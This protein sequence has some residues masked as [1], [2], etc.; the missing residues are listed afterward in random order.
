MQ[1]VSGPII[2]AVPGTQSK[3]RVLA[4]VLGCVVLLPLLAGCA[5]QELL[6]PKTSLYDRLLTGNTKAPA[7][8]GGQRNSSVSLASRDRGAAKFVGSVQAGTD[9]LVGRQGAGAANGL[10][11]EEKIT[12][13]LVD[14]PIANAAKTILS[15]ILK[16]SYSIDGQVSGTVTLQTS[17][18]M[19][20]SQVVQTFEQVLRANGAAI[21]RQGDFYRIVPAGQTA[22][23]VTRVETADSGQPAGLGVRTQVISLKYV[24]ADELRGVLEPLVPDGAIRKVD[25]AR[26]AIVLS[27]TSA[28]LATMRENIALFDVDWLQGMSFALFPVRSSS[29]AAIAEELDTIFGT[30]KGPLKGVV[31]FVPNKRLNA[32]LVISSRA[33]YLRESSQWIRK[34]DRLAGDNETELHVYNVQNRTASELAKVLQSVYRSKDGQ[35]V[36]IETTGVAP[37]LEAIEVTSQG[38]APPQQDLPPAVSE[39]A[40]GEVDQRAGLRVVA[41]D[42]NNVSDVSAYGTDL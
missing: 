37:R 27:G 28:E 3:C 34:L 42:A 38:D 11:D 25:S 9:Q 36:S 12:L 35:R 1:R 19:A 20:V 32:V 15:D 14:V 23:Q 6:E 4:F 18:P 40:G 31:R 7:T 26:N 29:P 5:S 39:T 2:L 33:K 21:V 24:S 41:D 8:A 22:G 16:A 10:G 13:N 30:R 17:Q